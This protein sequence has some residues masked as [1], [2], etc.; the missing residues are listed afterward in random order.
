MIDASDARR[1]I[2]WKKPDGAR[3]W[4]MTSSLFSTIFRASSMLAV[5]AYNGR[6]T[7]RYA[8]TSSWSMRPQKSRATRSA[9]APPRAA[10][11][12]IDRSKSQRAPI[13][14]RIS[15]DACPGCFAP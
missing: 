3:K 7:A 10:N 11:R 6:Q 2:R 5:A 4:R 15:F 13:D 8:T 1:S 9:S 14:D 12:R